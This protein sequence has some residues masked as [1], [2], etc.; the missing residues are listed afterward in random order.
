[1]AVKGAEWQERL[2]RGA[3]SLGINL[4]AEAAQRLWRHWQLVKEAGRRV[5]LTSIRDDA[6]ALTAHYV[7]SLL[8]L[9]LPE[10]WPSSGLLVDVG[11]G[12]GYPGIPLRVVLGGAWRVLLVEAVRKKAAFL[13][14]AAGELALEGVEVRAERAE[15][16]GRDGLWRDR[17]D[18]AVA[19]A[20][21]RLDVL[22]E[23][24]LPLVRVGGRLWVYKG[25]RAREEVDACR[26][27]VRAVGGEI[28]GQW[29]FLLP[30]SGGE[31]WLILVRKE[32]PTPSAFPRRPGLPRKRPLAGR[33][34][35]EPVA[36]AG[37]GPGS[38]A[39]NR[40][41]VGGGRC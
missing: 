22:V 20:L 16:M 26:S 13:E 41:G 23:Y 33:G 35:G 36:G 6:A 32:R 15:V 40:N 29:R 28:A 30:W 4:T 7:D 34:G 18:V 8:P 19:R 24:A 37:K 3:A 39:E 9:A 1:M 2:R 31:R 14:R 27:A 25:P 17:A 38:R 21:A 12:A 10:E 11:S 5:N